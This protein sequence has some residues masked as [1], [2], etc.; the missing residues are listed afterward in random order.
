M[1][2]G[3]NMVRCRDCGYHNIGA[4]YCARCGGDLY[5]KERRRDS[6]LAALPGLD[7]LVNRIFVSR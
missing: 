7:T 3:C 1:A 5:K 2:E 4:I 6:H